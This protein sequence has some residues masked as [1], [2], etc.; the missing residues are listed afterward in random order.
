MLPG[1][2]A[3]GIATF[4]FAIADS[5]DRE[6]RPSVRN[7][8]EGH[9]LTVDGTG[10]VFT[11]DA[12]GRRVKTVYSDGVTYQDYIIGRNGKDATILINGGLHFAELY[13]GGLH[14]ATYSGT[15]TY[16]SHADWT[17]TVRTHTY[18][19]GGSYATA[20]A[21]T[22]FIYGDGLNCPGNDV[23]PLHYT[24][25][26]WEGSGTGESNF[27]HFPYRQLSTTQGRWT[28]PD[29]SGM[30][31]VDVTRPQTWN[32]Y[33]YV[34][35]NPV[36]YVDPSGLFLKGPGGGGCDS[37]EYNCSGGAGTGDS[38][39]GFQTTYD[40]D[41]ELFSSAGQEWLLSTGQATTCP[42][43]D[44]SG[45]EFQNNGDIYK[46][47]YSPELDLLCDEADVKNYQCAWAAWSKQFVEHADTLFVKGLGLDQPVG[48]DFINCPD[49]CA[50]TI[51]AANQINNP[52]NIAL[53]YTTAAL[54]GI[55][56][57]ISEI[58][59]VGEGMVVA[60]ENQFPGGTED[61]LQQMSPS[62]SFINTFPG[63]AVWGAWSDYDW[64]SNH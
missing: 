6:D 23:T 45:L 2:A 19:S 42:D 16:F 12:Q 35:N 13:A 39:S 21:C 38:G 41:G 25:Q 15:T 43:N 48:G 49:G 11:Y 47:T 8:P 37:S 31:A 61:I 52:I 17:G 62:P 27:T 5:K 9:Q 14:L 22:S 26:F 60:F 29:P 33:A 3:I 20:E 54:P 59:E 28:T 58:I 63:L 46:N 4:T 57:S 36:S 1:P 30:A 18:P 44:C 7:C 34:S 24:G 53:W 50:G 51:Q 64:Y 10:N 32:R 56:Y 55:I 40:F